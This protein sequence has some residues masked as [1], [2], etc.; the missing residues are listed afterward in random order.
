MDD[1]DVS[2]FWQTFCNLSASSLSLPRSYGVESSRSFISSEWK[3]DID[4]IVN[5]KEYRTD[6]HPSQYIPAGLRGWIFG[7]G[8][9]RVDHDQIV[10]CD[11]K[12]FVFNEKTATS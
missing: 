7:V 1:Q 4:C 10:L 5:N 2:R 12:G 6:P 3:K 8:D 9:I 11:R